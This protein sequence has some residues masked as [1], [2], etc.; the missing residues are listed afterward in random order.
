MN[1]NAKDEIYV[2]LQRQF[3]QF[4]ADK[5]QEKDIGAEVVD[6]NKN[7]NTK[8]IGLRI[9]NGDV[10][11]QIRINDYFQSYIDDDMAISEILLDLE[12]IMDTVPDFKV[13]DTLDFNNA[14]DKIFF[15]LINLELNKNELENIP[16]KKFLDLA[17]IFYIYI[18]NG[19]NEHSIKITNNILEK[20]GI[21]VDELYEIAYNNTTSIYLPE[22]ASL[23]NVLP[24]EVDEQYRFPL[25]Y[26][27]N[28]VHEYGSNIICYKGLLK[29]ISNKFFDDKDF[30]I[31]PSSIHEVLL[32]ENEDYV[33]DLDSLISEV[34]QTEL[35][36]T[37]VLSPHA[38]IYLRNED[39]IIY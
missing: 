2:Q 4:I 12:K 30:T 16:Y 29:E 24:I 34:N 37:E 39:K 8:Y 20:W 26:A 6:I 33:E 35:N 32:V 15:R 36:E 17:I 10:K 14:K 1:K 25:F 38:Y 18:K 23:L 13:L 5:L 7:N 3:A 9:G 11:P 19:T 28:Q 21:T 31:I 27:S 22:V